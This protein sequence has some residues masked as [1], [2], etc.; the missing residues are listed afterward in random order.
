MGREVKTL[1]AIRDAALTLDRKGARHAIVSMGRYGAVYTDGAQTLF[2][3]AIQVEVR[4]H[5]GR[6]R[7]DG[8]RGA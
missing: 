1:R 4:L 5:R 6:G 7:R 8:R 2:A 3:P